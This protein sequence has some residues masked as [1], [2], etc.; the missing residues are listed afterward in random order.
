VSR[1]KLAA[2]GSAAGVWDHREGVTITGYTALFCFSAL[3]TLVVLGLTHAYRR[4]R[5]IAD[6]GYVQVIK[7]GDV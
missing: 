5:G 4:W 6:R 2:L 7:S 1:E 3:C